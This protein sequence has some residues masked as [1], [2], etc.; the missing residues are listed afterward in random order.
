MSRS[1][2]PDPYNGFKNDD[3]RRRA[4]NFRAGCLAA[5]GMATAWSH[6]LT[7]IQEA[8]SWLQTLFV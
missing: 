4:L 2:K 5:V 1:Y 3:E 8:L 6:P 7:N